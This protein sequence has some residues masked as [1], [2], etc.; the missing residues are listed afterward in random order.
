MIIIGLGNPEEKYAHTRHNIGWDC[1]RDDL[2]WKKDG[3]KLIAE[4]I[5]I[6]SLTGMNSSGLAIPKNI[7]PKELIVLVD[8]LDLPFGTIK[9]KTKGSARH[10]G[11]KSIEEAL[12]GNQDYIRIKIGIGKNFKP[13]EQ[14]NYVLSEF[15]DEEKIQIPEIIEK[16]RRIVNSI[17]INGIEWTKNN[18]NKI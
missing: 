7:D 15:N 18:L 13:G 1:L 5:Y 14:L 16:V 8:D 17:L 6:R 3:N 2:D 4:E 9:I 10:N 12:G 11:L